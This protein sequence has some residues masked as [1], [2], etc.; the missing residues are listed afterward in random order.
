LGLSEAVNEVFPDAKCQRCVV[1]FYRN[2]SRPREL[3]QA[4]S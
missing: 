3:Y 4:E 2:W 1:H